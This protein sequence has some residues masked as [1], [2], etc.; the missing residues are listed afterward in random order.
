MFLKFKYL[1]KIGKNFSQ[2][3]GEYCVE[4]GIFV[5]NHAFCCWTE[6]FGVEREL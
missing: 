3:G 2:E 5:S 4:P 6:L 1:N